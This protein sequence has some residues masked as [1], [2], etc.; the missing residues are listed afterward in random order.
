MSS[1]STST[2]TS[3]AQKESTAPSSQS[4]D[5]EDAWFVT[6]RK[7]QIFK[8]K[9]TFYPG[10]RWI[11]FAFVLSFFLVRMYMQ[12]GYAMLAYLLGLTYL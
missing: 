12:W 11:A 4:F 5:L 1:T 9:I 10:R 6:L 3:D 8:D 7:A 2:I